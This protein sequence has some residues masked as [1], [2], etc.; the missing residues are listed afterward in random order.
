MPRPSKRTLHESLD[1]R[2]QRAPSTVRAII[3][4]RESDPSSKAPPM[5]SQVAECE[6][7]IE[8]M[9]WPQPAL[10]PFLERESG[11]YHVERRVLDEVERLIQQR[12]VDVVVTLNFERIARLEE[13]RHAARYFARKYGV[14]YRFAELLPD[15]KLDESPMAKAYAG[16]LEVFGAMERDKIVARTKRGRAFRAKQGI[17]GGGRGGAPYGL[18]DATPDD[19]PYTRYARRDEEADRLLWMFQH[20][21]EHERVSFRSLAG[22]LNAKG[23]LTREGKRW[24]TQTVKE[25][26]TNPRYCGRGEVNRWEVT[27]VQKT[28][29]H[30]GETYDVR[31]VK[32]RVASVDADTDEDAQPHG[33][34]A[35]AANS[36]PVLIPP[37]LFD[38]VQAKLGSDWTGI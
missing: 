17:P 14:E 16:L 33:T 34:Y 6:K 4:A 36:E 15:G 30:S 32:P 20:Y 18:R 37:D 23:W 5:M 24:T 38:R 10:G 2:T 8:R 25:K 28:Y 22:Q 9:G 19:A 3:Y 27:R 35:F 13:R 1:Q 29:E 31:V 11:Y 12:Q 21:D 7:F 26:L